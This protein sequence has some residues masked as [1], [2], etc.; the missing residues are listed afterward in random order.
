MNVGETFLNL[1]LS[2]SHHL[3][4]VSSAANLENEFV[5]F[6]FTSWREG[7]DESCIVQ[8]GE[9]PFVSRETI[10][11]YKRGSLFS[12]KLKQVMENMGVFQEHVP[13]TGNLLRRIQEG[14]LNSEYTKQKYQAMVRGSI[15]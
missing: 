7:C 4:V 8:S 13:V 9:H 10:V 11:E 3:W 14:A 1:N 2:S 12:E 15:N 5:I 6:N